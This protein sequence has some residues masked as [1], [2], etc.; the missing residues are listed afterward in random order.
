[1]VNL[2]PSPSKWQ[3]MIIFSMTAH[4]LSLSTVHAAIPQFWCYKWL[5]ILRKKQSPSKFYLICLSIKAWINPFGDEAVWMFV[6]KTGYSLRLP[7]DYGPCGQPM[8]IHLPSIKSAWNQ[9]WPYWIFQCTFQV[10][11][12]FIHKCITC[13]INKVIFIKM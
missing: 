11:L 2:Q 7:E 4:T 13:W 5:N 8:P 10:I 3:I 1:M 12:P 6:G 9:N